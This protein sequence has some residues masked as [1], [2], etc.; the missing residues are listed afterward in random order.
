MLRASPRTTRLTKRLTDLLKALA[1]LL[2]LTVRRYATIQEYLNLY[3]KS[4]IQHTFRGDQ[5][6]YYLQVFQVFYYPGKD[7]Y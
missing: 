3:W 6:A 2:D 7:D 5:L 4:E 1:I